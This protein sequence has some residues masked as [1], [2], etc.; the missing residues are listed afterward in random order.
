MKNQS[1]LAQDEE[2]QTRVYSCHSGHIHVI[3]RR[4]NI[5]LSTGEF[6]ELLDCVVQTFEYI[7]KQ[8]PERMES[9]HIDV[10]FDDTVVKMP[11]PGFR[12]FVQ[13]LRRAMTS[14]QR[15]SGVYNKPSGV[16]AEY[17]ANG[18]LIPFAPCRYN[19]LN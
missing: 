5:A 17:I 1:L 16:E 19:Q 7:Q 12:T 9:K 2:N 10:T 6:R 3:Y 14:F 13:V 4:I 18:K 15:L 11:L 8:S